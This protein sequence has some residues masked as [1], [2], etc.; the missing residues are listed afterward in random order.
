MNMMLKF[1]NSSAIGGG[2]YA[3]DGVAGFGVRKVKEYDEKMIVEIYK[4]IVQAQGKVVPR[5]AAW[6][7]SGIKCQAI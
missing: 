1:A 3:G 2:M 7:S 6:V 4:S 5:D